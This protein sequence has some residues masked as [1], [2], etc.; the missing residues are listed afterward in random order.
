MRQLLN[1]M[2]SLDGGTVDESYYGGGHYQ[3]EPS[4]KEKLVDLVDEGRVDADTTAKEMANW[5][6]NDGCME[7]MEEYLGM[8]PGGG[9]GELIDLID[10][11][12]LDANE[13][14][15]GLANWFG[16]ADCKEFMENELGIEESVEEAG[17][18]YQ[19]PGAD[20][21]DEV[22][23]AIENGGIDKDY[24]IMAMIKYMSNEDVKKMLQMNDIN[25]D[26]SGEY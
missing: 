14:V 18:H 20:I 6:G 11:G 25:L 15:R 10:D 4:Y 21:R 26:D 3:P 17:E 22:L 19:P 7:F 16:P 1:E 9:V 24:I 8:E 23:A 5:L 2:T 12:V 13:A